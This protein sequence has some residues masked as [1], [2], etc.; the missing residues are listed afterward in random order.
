MGGLRLVHRGARSLPGSSRAGA[1]AVW[2][3]EPGRLSRKDAAACLPGPGAAM[4][5]PVFRAGR[6]RL[7]AGAVALLSLLAINYISKQW[8]TRVD[9]TQDKRYTLSEVSKK[10]L[11]KIQNP[12]VI[13]VLL[14]GNIPTEFK[15]LQTETIQLLDEYAAANSNIIVNFVNPLEGEERPE[16]VIQELINNGYQPLQ[17]TQNEA[18]QTKNTGKMVVSHGLD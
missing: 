15:K 3:P 6:H 11:A 1:Q 12:I 4:A 18:N 8:H 14:K 16:S 5:G 10:T 9:L 13:D 7:P 17:I 2:L